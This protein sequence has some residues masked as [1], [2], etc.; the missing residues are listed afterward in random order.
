MITFKEFCEERELKEE[1][2]E[3]FRIFLLYWIQGRSTIEP[4]IRDED[5]ID[6]EDMNDCL[7]YW[8]DNLPQRDER[9]KEKPNEL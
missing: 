8:E 6:Y 5:E 9:N 7:D 4:P 1:D 3:N 2:K